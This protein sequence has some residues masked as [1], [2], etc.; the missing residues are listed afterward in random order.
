VGNSSFTPFSSQVLIGCKLALRDLYQFCRR[1]FSDSFQ[2]PENPMNFLNRYKIKV[3]SSILFHE[4]Q[5]VP[6]GV[7]SVQTLAALF[8]WG[9]ISI[10]AMKNSDAENHISV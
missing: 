2:T 8:S 5:S 9:K 7:H 3:W 4:L 10:R 1:S 6:H